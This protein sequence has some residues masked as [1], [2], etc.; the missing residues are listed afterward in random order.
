MWTRPTSEPSRRI[1]APEDEVGCVEVAAER[2][3]VD[4][5]GELTYLVRRKRSL[6]EQVDSAARGGARQRP[7]RRNRTQP[8]AVGQE[9]GVPEEG[10]QEGRDAE[11]FGPPDRDADLLDSVGRDARVGVRDPTEIVVVEH[12][13]GHLEARRLGG[14]LQGAEAAAAIIAEVTGG[15]HGLDPLEACPPRPLEDALIVGPSDDRVH[16]GHPVICHRRDQTK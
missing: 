14:T 11:L 2:R 4:R 7:E 15:E 16:D 9:L 6:V 13:R 8:V 3:R 10:D 1:E 12:E 5:L